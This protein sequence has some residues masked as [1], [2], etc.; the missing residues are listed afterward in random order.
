[1]SLIQARDETTNST[2]HDVTATADK[3]LNVNVG[4]ISGTSPQADDAAFTIG[5]PVTMAGGV[6][7]SASPDSVDDGDGGAIRMSANRNMYTQ[8]RD[9]TNERS[10]NVTASNELNVIESNLS[11]SVQTDGSAAPAKSV[12]IGATDGTN[13]QMLSADTSGQLKLANFTSATTSNRVEEID[14]VSAHHDESNLVT[15]TSIAATAYGY[16]DMDGYRYFTIQAKGTI[17]V[18]TLTLTVEA[19]CEDNGTAQASCDYTDVTQTLF[20]VASVSI[21]ATGTEMFICTVPVAF[22]YLRLKYVPVGGNNDADLEVHF[23]KM[24]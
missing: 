20:G 16:A 21:A 11:A 3:Y 24:F 1:M 18:D 8:L 22:K 4:S 5:D 12:A 23:K 10:A 15:A 17:T 6:Y 14:P 2:H 13:L 9:S 7:Q 19:S